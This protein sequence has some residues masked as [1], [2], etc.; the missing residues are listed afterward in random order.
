MASRA[1]EIRCSN[2]FSNCTGSTSATHRASSTS[3]V[4]CVSGSRFCAMSWRCAISHGLME[5]GLASSDWRRE[6]ASSRWVRPA[7]RLADVTPMSIRL[8]SSSVL[9]RATLRRSN[10]ILPM[11]PASMLFRSWAIPPVSWPIASI[12]C[13]WRRSSLCLSCSSTR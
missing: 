12:F 1:F 8:S 13:A 11:I 7:A 9:P 2:A 5:R 3:R 6:K 10:S 4:S